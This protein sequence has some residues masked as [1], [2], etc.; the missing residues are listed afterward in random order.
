MTALPFLKELNAMIADCPRCRGK[1][2]TYSFDGGERMCRACGGTGAA[3]RD[4][5]ETEGVGNAGV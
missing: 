1:G 2:E 5:L 4:E 3:K